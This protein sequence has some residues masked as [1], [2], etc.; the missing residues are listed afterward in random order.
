MLCYINKLLNDKKRN[1]HKN[2]IKTNISM[3][4]LILEKKNLYLLYKI[5]LS[6][7]I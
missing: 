4:D 6:S 2:N 3:M 7:Y 1:L 5:L